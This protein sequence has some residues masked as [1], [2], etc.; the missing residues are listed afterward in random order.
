[1]ITTLA[2]PVSQEDVSKT[3]ASTAFISQAYAQTENKIDTAGVTLDL[4]VDESENHH[5]FLIQVRDA[6]SDEI[7]GTTKT[8]KQMVDLENIKKKGEYYI[9][10]EGKGHKWTKFKVDY[11]G[12]K[13]LLKVKPQSS[14]IPML[15]QRFT[16]TKEPASLETVSVED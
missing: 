7:I 12:K 6:Q 9:Y 10:L 1:M 8:D 13:T 2:S 14:S 16:G 4:N 5:N 3:F 11:D 15:F